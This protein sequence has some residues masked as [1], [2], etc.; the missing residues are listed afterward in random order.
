MQIFQLFVLTRIL[1]LTQRI[2]QRAHLPHAGTHALTQTRT[3][4]RVH[5]HSLTRTHAH[6]HTYLSPPVTMTTRYSFADV[7]IV[8]WSV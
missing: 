3:H 4:A 1:S 5:T 7:V 8:Y 6:K 2:I